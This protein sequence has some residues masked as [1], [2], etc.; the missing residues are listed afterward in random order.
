MSLAITQPSPTPS[1]HQ[2]ID[3]RTRQV[4]TERLYHDRLIQLLYDDAREN[5][6]TLFHALTSA[7]VSK[8]LGYLN[9]DWLLGTRL[10]GA[11]N[12]LR[13]MQIDLSECLA[14]PEEL[15]TVRRVFERQIRYWQ[16]RPMPTAECIV[17]SPCDA[18]VLVGSLRETTSLYLKGK[19]FD[20][21]ELI[22]EDRTCRDKFDRADFAIFRLTPEKYHY[23]HM[24]V[25][26]V[27]CEQY[28]LD[29][30]YHSCNPSA[31]VALATPYSKNKRVVTVIDTDVPGGTGVGSVAMVEIVA[32]M[33]GQVAQCYS[34]YRYDD[35]VRLQPG[36]FVTRGQPK[37]LFRPGSSTVVLLFERDRVRF[38]DDLIANMSARAVSRFS[39][40]F[41]QS[42]VETD[43]R[44]RSWLAYP[45]P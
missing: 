5:A 6:P 42:L 4:R 8:L 36:S 27:V 23:N 15:N 2:Y 44:V 33:I 29:G 16:C 3:R 32:L 10:S 19:F 45:C 24:P 17:V 7:R 31:V 18:R 39:Q 26:G 37:S 22:G 35:P 11:E 30:R 21:D 41:G 9:Y 43:V 20:L 40:G 14:P 13:S 28:E 1:V 38:A 12:F 34:E 25:S